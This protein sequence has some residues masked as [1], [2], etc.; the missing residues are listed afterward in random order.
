MIRSGL[1]MAIVCLSLNTL[2]AQCLSGDCQNG[3]SKY[4]FR[5][6]AI[7]E[8]EMSYGKIHGLG[9]LIF[10]NGDVYRGYWKMN[11]REGEGILNTIDGL[12]Y[13]GTFANNLLNGTARV[14]DT[15]TGGYFEGVWEKGQKCQGGY[16]CRE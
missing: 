10:A 11:K 3:P 9:T 5:N 12:S 6:G 4:Q 13:Q 15:T 1:F 16:I 8:G 14:Y 7:Y 2:S